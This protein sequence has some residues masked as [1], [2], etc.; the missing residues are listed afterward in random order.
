MTVV[1]EDTGLADLLSTA[2]FLMPYDKGRAFVENLDGVE[3][4][5][6][7]NDGRVEA[8]DG[9]KKMLKSYGASGAL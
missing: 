4:V 8:T 1:T 5:W 2:V 7:L 6:V 9:I 3:A